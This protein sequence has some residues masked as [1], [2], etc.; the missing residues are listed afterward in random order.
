MEEFR[1]CSKCGKQY[2]AGAEFCANCG[3]PIRSTMS[4]QPAFDADELASAV[5]KEL[6]KTET[7]EPAMP[8]FDDIIS[9]SLAE[10]DSFSSSEK[11]SVPEAPAFPDFDDIIASSLEES[12]SVPCT[13]PEVSSEPASDGLDDLILTSLQQLKEEQSGIE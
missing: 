13:E 4:E 3:N 12:L 11:A 7:P 5:L 1:Y 8:D 6:N 2:R 10:I 9:S